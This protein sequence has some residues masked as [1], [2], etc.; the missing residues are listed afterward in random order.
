MLKLLTHI[1]LSCTQLFMVNQKF[2]N[3]KKTPDREKMEMKE[4]ILTR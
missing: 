4:V 3:P 2:G 1:S